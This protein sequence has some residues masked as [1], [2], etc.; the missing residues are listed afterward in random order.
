MA[1]ISRC[2][3]STSK[4]PPQVAGALLDV[5]EAGKGFGGDHGKGA[6]SAM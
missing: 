3:C 5:F 6:Q 1:S 4:K 2:F